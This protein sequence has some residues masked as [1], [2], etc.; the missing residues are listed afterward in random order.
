[1]D[2]TQE[3]SETYSLIALLNVT[4]N[5]SEAGANSKAS[6]SAKSNVFSFSLFPTLRISHR[7]RQVNRYYSNEFLV[8]ISSNLRM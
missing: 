5:S 1:M 7:R 2:K 6:A 4:L 8:G 3:T